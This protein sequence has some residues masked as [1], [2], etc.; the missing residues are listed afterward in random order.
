M[1]Y[2]V[3]QY[4]FMRGLEWIHECSFLSVI[5]LSGL[6]DINLLQ[7]TQIISPYSPK[8]TISARAGLGL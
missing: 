2:L 5:I 4:A 1:F 8:F 7:V 6:V 3:I